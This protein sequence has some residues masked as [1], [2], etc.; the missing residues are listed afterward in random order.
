MRRKGYSGAMWKF[1]AYSE[2]GKDLSYR[3]VTYVSQFIPVGIKG[4]P[5]IEYQMIISDFS[6]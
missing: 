5:P 4:D 2:T 6:N 3:N 1:K